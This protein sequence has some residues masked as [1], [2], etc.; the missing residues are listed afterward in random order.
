[1]QTCNQR[2]GLKNVLE[3]LEDSA[4]RCPDKVAFED[5][6]TR[7]TYK[8][9]LAMSRRIGSA[10]AELTEARRPIPVLGEKSVETV[11]TFLGIV[12]AGCFYV[13][14]DPKQPAS[15]LK[16]ILKTLEAE[17]LIVMSEDH[18]KVS[19]MLEFGGKILSYGQLSEAEENQSVLEKIRTNAADTDPLY[20][21]FT[22]GSTG[23]PKGVVVSH[24]SV[25]D[26]MEY[27]PELFDITENDVIGNQAPFDFDVSV[28]DIYSTVK[29]GATMVMIPKQYFSF[30]TKLLDYL[31]ERNV[32]TL[33]WAVSAVCIISTLKGFEYK[34]PEKVNKVL[35]S[36]EVMPI[37]H[38]NIWRKYL[39]EAQ[40]VNLYG[41][42]EITCNCTYYKI[43]REF[44]KGDVLPI[45][46]PFPNEK[47]FLLD[48]EEELV[49]EA[50]KKGELC[51]AG[52]ALALG[53]Y[54]AP[55]Q[56]RK[57]FVQNP[58]NP[59]YPEMI[60]RTG[61]L[62]YYNEDG[63]LC[64]A[65]RK[66]FQIKHMGHRIELG[67]IETAMDRIDAIV[68]ACC[69]FYEEKKRILAFY[70]GEIEKKEIVQALS[71]I[72]PPFMIPNTFYKREHLPVTKNGKIDRKALMQEAGIVK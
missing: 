31:C 7:C 5:E 29:T 58:L 47:V 40:F 32:T 39:P 42:T 48:E 26:F 22:S 28:K 8:E 64:Y 71:K 67:E 34:V 38:L 37:K 60:Y 63:E 20:V 23:I 12:H 66:D 55:E 53:Y 65:S 17:T 6:K 45:G 16:Q 69:V 21:N 4:K 56:T 70:E 51:V 15:R 36:G 68:R 3:Y 44:E 27:F 18:R 57:A 62:A 54:Q 30:P 43:E 10:L 9:T 61:D 11:Q 50:Y 41:P 52:T 25:I 46:V 14:L 19:D 1:M 49:K 24:R 13:L 2:K 35:F 33:I 59:Y 72:L